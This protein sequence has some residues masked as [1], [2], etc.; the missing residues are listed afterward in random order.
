MLPTP[1]S[2]NGDV[3]C[4]E[5]EGE[6]LGGALGVALGEGADEAVTGEDEVAA[7]VHNGKGCTMA[8]VSLNAETVEPSAACSR[9]VCPAALSQQQAARLTKVTLVRANACPRS[10]CQYSLALEEPPE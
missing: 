10:T 5:G 7:I 1:A 2:T 6:A 9:S 4:A 3:G 8:P